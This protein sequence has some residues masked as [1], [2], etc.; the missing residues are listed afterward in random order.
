MCMCVCVQRGV[1]QLVRLDLFSP[2][3]VR[4]GDQTQVVSL[5]AGTFNPLSKLSSHL[6]WFLIV[7]PMFTHK[8]S[9]WDSSVIFT[10][11]LSGRAF[12]RL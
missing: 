7:H 10:P 6:L 3:L 9:L 4:S 1:G 8:S 2:L 5:V 11:V 12:G